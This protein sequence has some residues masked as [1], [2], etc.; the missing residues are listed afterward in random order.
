[1][2]ISSIPYICAVTAYTTEEFKSKCI[3]NGMDEFLPKPVE[4][5]EIIKLLNKF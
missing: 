3:Q 4:S 5:L 2:K 1:L